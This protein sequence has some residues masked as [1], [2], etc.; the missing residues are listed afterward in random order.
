ME[1][2]PRFYNIKRLQSDKDYDGERYFTEGSSDGM[3]P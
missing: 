1:S 2:L 3:G